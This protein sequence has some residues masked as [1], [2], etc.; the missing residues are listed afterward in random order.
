MKLI[1]C[2]V[3]ETNLRK[4]TAEFSASEFAAAVA[5]AYMK[6]RKKYRVPGF[7]PGKAPQRM[8]EK[9]YGEGVFFE[10]A[11][12]AILSENYPELIKEAGLRPVDSPKDFDVTTISVKEGVSFSFNVTVRP[13]LEVDGYKGITVYRPAV[14]ITDEQVDKRIEGMLEQNARVEDIEGRPAENG[15]IAVIDF[16]GFVDG[17]AF[18]GGTGED[19]DLTLGSG[20]F[21][22][23]F[24]EQIVGHNPGDEFD[25]NVTFPEQY[26]PELAGKDATFKVLLNAIRKKILPELDDEFVKDVSE[27]DTLDEL[28]SE[29]REE[30]TKEAQD[31]ADSALRGN[32]YDKVAGLASGEIPEVMI[33]DAVARTVENFEYRLNMQGLS[34][35]SYLQ[36]TGGDIN[37]FEAQVRPQAEKDLKADLALE[38]I[39]DKEGFEASEEAIAERYAKLAEDYKM[40]VDKVKESV[41]ENT[42]VDELKLDFAYELVK[43]N[44]VITDEPEDEPA[45]EAETDAD[46]KSEEIAEAAQE[47]AEQVAEQDAES[48]E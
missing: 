48:A 46:G 22:P 15:D 43:E 1:S 8:I 36:Y 23:G 34:L 7:R 28:K 3:A 18:E 38:A 30:L 12:D 37:D 21:I 42:I 16:T 17:E 24:E 13:T 47:A 2:E 45:E 14:E 41:S 11:F 4:V 29:I 31:R 35:D 9:I 19:Y 6:T 20:Q 26:A 5:K 25:V 39:A 27:H 32:I 40:D 10:D 33:D 44:A